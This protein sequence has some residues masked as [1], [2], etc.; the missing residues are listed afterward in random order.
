[1]GIPID[2]FVEVTLAAFF[3]IAEVVQPLTVCLNDD[4]SDPYSGADF[5][6]GVQ[7]IDAA[8]AM[9]FVRQR[10]D[11]NDETFTDLD[12]TRRQQAFHCLPNRR[13]QREWC[14]VSSD[15]AA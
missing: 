2:H 5:E 3:Q 8:Q 13:D 9:A 7:E 11:V 15:R 14:A 6:R 1:M 4:T 10:R 12:R